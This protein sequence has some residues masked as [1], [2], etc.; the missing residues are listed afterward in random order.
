M[1]FNQRAIDLL[2]LPVFPLTWDSIL[3]ECARLQEEF[4]HIPSEFKWALDYKCFEVERAR[5]NLSQALS[6]L[7]TAIAT[8]PYNND[9]VADYRQ[10]VKKTSDVKALVLIVSSRRTVANAFRLAAQ[11]DQHDIQYMIVSGTDAPSIQHVRALQVDA[12]DSYEA[13]PQKVVAALTWVYENIGNE[14][15]VLKVSDQ[16]VLQDASQLRQALELL[17][18]ENVYSGVPVNAVELDRCQHWGLCRDQHLNRRLYGRPSLRDW[19]STHAYFLGARQVEQVVLSTLRF[20]GLFEGEYYDDKLIGDILVL[21]SEGMAEQSDFGV[22]GL[23]HVGSAEP[24]QPA[25]VSMA[26]SAPAAGGLGMAA[27]EQSIAQRGAPANGAPV[28]MATPAAT[29]APPAVAANTAGTAPAARKRG[30]TLKLSDW[31]NR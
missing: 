25:D 12:S 21:E 17:A 2:Q 10:T 31:N 29:A 13:E 18:R 11:L 7:K 16:M 20:P 24:V 1:L 3:K 22:F 30:N 26:A 14:T 9:L 28:T 8:A 15:A 5:G 19:A 27:P 6:Y 4:L 23:A